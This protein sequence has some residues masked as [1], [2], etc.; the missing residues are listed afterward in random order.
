MKYSKEEMVFDF[1]NS[2]KGCQAPDSKRDPKTGAIIRWRSHNRLTHDMKIAIKENLKNY[3]LEEICIAIDN[4]AKVLLRDEFYWTH[5]WPLSTFLTVKH[6]KCKDDPKKWWR[7][8]PEN[9]MEQTLLKRGRQQEDPTV[10]EDPNPDLTEKLMKKLQR[11]GLCRKGFVPNNK[12]IGQIRLTVQKMMTFYESRSCK[13]TDIWLEDLYDCLN[14]NYLSK[15]DAV[16]IG[17]LCS[18]HVWNV[19]MPQL[20]RTCGNV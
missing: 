4:Y 14:Y 9:F 7:F 5:I 13:D 12:Q 3:S 17:L 6:G 11:W 10:M 18:D 19:L 16:S 15:A 2:F 1:W 20:L 8:L